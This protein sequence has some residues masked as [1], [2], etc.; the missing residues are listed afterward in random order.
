MA[1]DITTQKTTRG[2]EALEGGPVVA[3]PVD[4]YEGRDEILVVADVPG[5]KVDG[6]TVRLEKNELHLRARREG[7]RKPELDYV[8]TFLIPR[9]VDAQKIE[10]E[11]KDGVLTIHLPKSEAGKPRQIAVRAA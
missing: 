6:V 8:R 3:P 2:A 10:A 1:N 11:L 5:V 4:I 9:S 7:E